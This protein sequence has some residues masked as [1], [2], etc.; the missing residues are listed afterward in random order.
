MSNRKP[1]ECFENESGCM[2][3]TSHYVDGKGYPKTSKDGRTLSVPRYIWILLNGEI[4]T[5]LVVRH[6][7]DNP[8]CINPEHLELGTVADNNRDMIERGR[9]KGFLKG[10][11]NPKAKLTSFVV[12]R[13][14]TFYKK[15]SGYAVAKMFGVDKK[16]IYNIR[17]GK[18]WKHV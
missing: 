6:K 17:N 7:C 18:T 4:P 3:C 16:T 5:G 11:D 12:K 13:I 2:V 14:K 9:Y 8:A 15:Y 1:I 10:N